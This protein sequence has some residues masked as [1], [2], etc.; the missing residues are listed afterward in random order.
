MDAN[1]MLRIKD[2][3]LILPAK[4]GQRESE[5]VGDHE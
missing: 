3:I 2:G 4:C 1:G 5:R